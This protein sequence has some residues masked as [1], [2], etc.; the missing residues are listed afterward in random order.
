MTS[1]KTLKTL[2]EWTVQE[3]EDRLLFQ[4]KSAVMLPEFELMIDDYLGFIIS[5]Y[6]WLLPENHEIYTTNL[7]SVCNITVSELLRNINSLYICPGVEP[8]ELFSNIVHHL[9]PKSIDPLFIDSDGD[10][11][12]FSHKEY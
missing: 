2:Q 6:G 7:R 10:V 8:S 4:K 3:L 12:S 9:I 1:V 5:V 11:N